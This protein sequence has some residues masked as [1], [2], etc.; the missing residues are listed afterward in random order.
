MIIAF[1]MLIRSFMP[2]LSVDENSGRVVLLGGLID[3]NEKEG[4]V[5]LGKGMIH[6]NASDLEDVDFDVQPGTEGT[7]SLKGTIPLG[8]G[9]QIKV[10]SHNAKMEFKPATGTELVYDCKMASM[11]P[12]DAQ[13]MVKVEGRNKVVFELG[14]SLMSG[15]KCEFQMPKE[16]SLNVA[17]A[18]GK[19]EMRDLAQDIQ[20]T[21]ANGKIEFQKEPK[22]RYNL[23][24]AVAQGKVE[25]HSP[26][27]A[28]DAQN[29]GVETG[30]A[31]RP[32]KVDLT[33]GNGKIEV[34]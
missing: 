19:I 10:L 21:L 4:K 9:A 20:A 30:V 5:S 23:T 2:I 28:P 12:M 26:E 32:F 18:N 22:S 11:K 27:V 16:T 31:Q 8:K 6:V 33:V 15:A 24:T 3:V 13:K 17:V 7:E 14:K 29:P 1:V 34:Q 25:D